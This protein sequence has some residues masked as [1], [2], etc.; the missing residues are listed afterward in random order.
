MS[1]TGSLIQDLLPIPDTTA[2]VT[3][4]HKKEVAQSLDDEP[5]LSHALATTELE[6]KG[7]AQQDHDEEVVNLGWNEPKENI[8]N[9]LVG[10]IDNEDLWL[11]VRRFNKQT[12]HFKEIERP[13]SGRLDLNVAEEEE[14]SPDKLR[15]N[16]ERLYMTVVI[17]FLS[18][19]KHIARLRS[20]RETRRSAWFCAVYYLAWMFD[21]LVPML[22]TV[23]IALI[24]WPKSREIM[25]PPAPIA[26]VDGKSG[27]SIK[28]GFN[29]I[30]PTTK[31]NVIYRRRPETKSRSSRLARL[32]H[33]RSR[34]PQRR[35]R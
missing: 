3:D 19:I 2:P 16:I 28:S 5:T 32:R 33:R 17:G 29:R 35:S 30:Q 23:F 20:W 13:V 8:E 24:V 4:P 18:F 6:E 9:P 25:F 15:S 27:E 12:Y 7:A 11:L 31:S 21:F 34:K 1:T 26:L 10:G 14:F 22:C